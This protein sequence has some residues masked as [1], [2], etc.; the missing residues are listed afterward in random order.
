M[1]GIRKVAMPGYVERRSLKKPKE[2]KHQSP[3]YADWNTTTQSHHNLTPVI[4]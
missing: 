1:A 2:D 4:D 3:I